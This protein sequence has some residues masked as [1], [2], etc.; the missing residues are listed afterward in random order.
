[1]YS[2][3]SGQILFNNF[4]IYVRAVL[5]IIIMKKKEILHNNTITLDFKYK[6]NLCGFNFENKYLATV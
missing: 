1:M 6:H 5:N 4:D 3:V 2:L